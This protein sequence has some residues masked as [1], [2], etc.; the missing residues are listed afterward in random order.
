MLAI[1]NVVLGVRK[2]KYSIRNHLIF[3]L[4]F[5]MVQTPNLAYIIHCPYQ[6][7]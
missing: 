1:V 6:L 7:S 5:I 4:F 3:I 2:K